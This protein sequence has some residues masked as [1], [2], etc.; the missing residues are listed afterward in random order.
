MCLLCECPHNRDALI[1]TENGIDVLLS[2]IRCTNPI[3][4]DLAMNALINFQFNKKSL[5]VSIT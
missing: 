1:N 5:S 2:L 4:K 3:Q